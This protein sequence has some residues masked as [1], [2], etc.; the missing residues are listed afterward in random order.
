M[1]KISLRTKTGWLDKV[2][3]DSKTNC[4]HCRAELWQAPHGGLYCDRVH[5]EPKE[6][7]LDLY[8]I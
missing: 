4:D 5:E 7:S 1:I 3:N 6:A 8:T 2:D